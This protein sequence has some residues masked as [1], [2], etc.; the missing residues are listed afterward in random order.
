MSSAIVIVGAQWG[1]EGK[2]KVVDLCAERAE[3]VARFAGG[4][5]AGHTLVVGDDKVVVRLLPSGILHPKTTCVLA[6]G[7]VI[8]PAVLVGEIDALHAR[9]HATDGRLFVSDRAHLIL[10]YHP[11][12]DGLRESAARVGKKIGTTKRGIGP[13]YE[14]K[15]GR[16]GIRAGDLRDL[17]RVEA[18]MEEALEA[19]MP[20]LR[21]LGGEAPDVKAM[22]A[23]LEPLAARVVPLL[24]DTSKLLNDAIRAGKRMVLE[25]AQ[26]ALL[27]LDHGTYPYVTS[28]SAVAGGAC[29]GA[30]IGPT[31][32]HRVIGIAKGYATRVGEG[33]FPTELVDEIGE[34]LRKVGGEYG[35]VTGRP[36]RTG[37][38][39]LP[40]LRY[41]AR[42]NGLDALAITKLD[43]MTGLSE[44]KVCTAYETAAGRTEDLPIDELGT[45][46]PVLEALPG[47]SEP[48]SPARSMDELPAAARDYLKRI[49][50]AV[51]VPI[52]M[53]SVGARRDETIVLRDVFA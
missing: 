6:Q 8:D 30:G 38:L 24:A 33:P 11:L 15:A 51:G 27:D 5:N 41:A 50:E 14:D 1:D 35:S 7:M 25:G 2:G 52:E 31:R 4:P 49:E 28:S 37:W 39:D 3:V 23:S 34:R 16:R 9:G 44:I 45:A 48:L 21:G 19:W 29:V 20:T 42:V 12:I 32:I 47:W 46:R 18:L 17:G 13:C 43:V 10:P 53:V 40:A 22:V 36:R 26:A